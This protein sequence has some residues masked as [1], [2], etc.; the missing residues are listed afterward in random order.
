MLTDKPSRS[1]NKIVAMVVNSA[2]APCPYPRRLLP[3]RSATVTTIRFQP[4]LVPSPRL[5]ATTAFIQMGV[6]SIAFF[7][8]YQALAD[9]LFRS[10]VLSGVFGSLR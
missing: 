5:I 1:A 2:E 4:I 6:Y 9:R 3:I 7:N 8:E 10:L